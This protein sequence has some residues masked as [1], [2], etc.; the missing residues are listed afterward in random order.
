MQL[1]VIK[2]YLS[3]EEVYP[4]HNLAKAGHDV[5]GVSPQIALLLQRLKI[6]PPPESSAGVGTRGEHSHIIDLF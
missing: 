6:R 2:H 4:L 1:Y 5:S 3:K